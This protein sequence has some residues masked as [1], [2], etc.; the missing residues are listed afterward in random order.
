MEEGK[1]IIDGDDVF[2][3]VTNGQGKQPEE[4]LL[5]AHDSY[6]DIQLL[7]TGDET[8]GWKD[9]STCNDE[10]ADVRPD[11]DIIFFD[12]VPDI[13]FTLEPRHIAIFFPHDAHAPMIGE[14]QIKKV[15]VKVKL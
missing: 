4:A 2:A 6:I 11:N 7:M 10:T 9:R 12:D 14:G 15:V 3:S 8:M 1:H 13:Y 5:E